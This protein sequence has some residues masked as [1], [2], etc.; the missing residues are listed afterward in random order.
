[1]QA[2]HQT[3]LGH[4]RILYLYRR[5]KWLRLYR[6][7]GGQSRRLIST[8]WLARTNMKLFEFIFD[9]KSILMKLFVNWWRNCCCFPCQSKLE[10]F[11]SSFPS[12]I[13]CLERCLIIVEKWEVI[14]YFKVYLKRR[15]T[16]RSSVCLF[17]TLI[18]SYFP[19]TGSYLVINFIKLKFFFY[20]IVIEVMQLARKF[21]GTK[22][23]KNYEK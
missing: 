9:E 10:T 22:R 6:H 5:F 16:Y 14:N 23:E 1:L 21:Y 11:Y 19:S 8:R 2:A 17:Y 20:L 18:I 3:T 4:G 12:D 7:R 13:L 15:V